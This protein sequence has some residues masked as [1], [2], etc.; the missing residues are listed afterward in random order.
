MK[1]TKDTKIMFLF[2][3]LY[4]IS[5]YG[6]FP[7]D[8]LLSKLFPNLPGFVSKLLFLIPLLIAVFGF[9]YFRKHK[10]EISRSALLTGAVMI[11]YLL[12]PWYV[13]EIMVCLAA[14]LLIFTPLVFMVFAGPMVIW[15]MFV[16]GVLYLVGG[17]LFSLAYI[18]KARNE[19]ILGTVFSAICAV[20]QFIFVLDVITM[21]VMTLKEKKH[22][23]ATIVMLAVLG[24]GS[25]AAVVSFIVKILSF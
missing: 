10:E 16:L 11:K 9:L 14:L 17:S 22:I 18:G 1:K 15:Y 19:G 12:I 20:C 25:V 6:V 5:V 23:V 24:L 13:F 2:A 7:L 3:I 4:L 21:I 8:I